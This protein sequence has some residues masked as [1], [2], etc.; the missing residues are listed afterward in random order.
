[1]FIVYP[2]ILAPGIFFLDI[3]HFFVRGNWVRKEVDVNKSPGMS[4]SWV[5]V[6]KVKKNREESKDEQER[7]IMVPKILVYIEV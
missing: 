6:T 5:E 2:V 3:C 1:M 4:T 7:K